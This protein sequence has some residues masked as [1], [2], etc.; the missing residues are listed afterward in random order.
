M[1]TRAHLAVAALIVA[2]STLSGGWHAPRGGGLS[3]GWPGAT[4]ASAA[5]FGQEEAKYIAEVE[6]AMRRFSSELARLTDV[7]G[8]LPPAYEAARKDFAEKEQALQ[9]ALS[10]MTAGGSDAFEENKPAVEAAL[11][12]LEAAYRRAEQALR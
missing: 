2:F 10:T 11:A 3:R 4:T 6:N 12:A 7:E 9:G 1:G 8:A 5:T